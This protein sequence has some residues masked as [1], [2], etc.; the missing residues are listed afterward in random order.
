M[1]V[2]IEELAGHADFVPL[3]QIHGICVDLRYASANNFASRNLYGA[4]DCA[5]LHREAAH[6][7]RQSVQWLSANAPGRTLLVLDALRPHRVQIEL[8][9]TLTDP[10][11]RQY[12]A[13]PARGS[14]HSFGMAVDVTLLNAEGG[15]IGMGSGF[16][17][18]SALSHPALEAQHLAQGLLTPL[19]I[20]HRALLRSAMQAGGFQGINSEW[21]HFDCG[22]RDVVRA[23]YT[24]VE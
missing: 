11:E 22:Q 3:A 6:G 1:S 16:D 9:N 19:H 10:N 8:W 23:T 17:E 14:I 15:E 21:W 7:L 18:L 20:E 2:R 5:Y 24:R 13:D 12:L 4:L